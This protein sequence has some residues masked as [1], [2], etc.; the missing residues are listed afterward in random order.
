MQNMVQISFYSNEQMRAKLGVPQNLKQDRQLVTC[1][2]WVKNSSKW[3]QLLINRQKTDNYF[4]ISMT[5]EVTTLTLL[6]L[7][8]K[9]HKS[10]VY[11][12]G[13]VLNT[14]DM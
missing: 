1:K 6:C 14:R 10:N 8:T 12:H 2:K 5:D 7:V 13:K 4:L 11:V 3:I 9:G